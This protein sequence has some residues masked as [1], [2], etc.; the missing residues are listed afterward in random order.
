[1]KLHNLDWI[2]Q[3]Y[4]EQFLVNENKNQEKSDGRKQVKRKDTGY[5]KRNKEDSR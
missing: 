3:L 5:E 4:F 2:E 1:V